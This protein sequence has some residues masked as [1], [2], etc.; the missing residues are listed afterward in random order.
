M[1]PKIHFVKIEELLLLYKMSNNLASSAIFKKLPKVN[2]LLNLSQIRPMWSPWLRREREC[3]RQ[4]FL[5]SALDTRVHSFSAEIKLK[6]LT[7]IIF[8]GKKTKVNKIIQN[9]LLLKASA[10]GKTEALQ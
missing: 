8:G 9:R 1:W 2:K 3:L 10:P 6:R 7:R 5:Y 4:K